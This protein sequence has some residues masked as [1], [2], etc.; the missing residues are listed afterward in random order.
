MPRLIVLGI[1]SALFFSS[2]FILNRSMSLE[3][4]HWAWSASLRFGY[5]LVFLAL[6]LLVTQGKKALA[7]VWSVFRAYWKFWVVAGSIGF[8][9]FYAL[10]TLSAQYAAGWIVATTWQTTILAT[11]L[12]LVFFGRKVPTKGLVFTG[13]IFVGIVLVNLEHAVSTSLR[14]LFWG[15]MPVL[16]AAVAYPL[17]N[18]LVWEVRVGENRHLPHIQHPIMANGFARVLLMTLGSMPF[19]VGLLVLSAPPA[20]SAGQWLNTALVA[21]FSGVFATTLFLY[22]RNL[23]QKPY[24]IAA[25]DATQSMEVVFSLLGEVIFLQGLLPG[26]LGLAGV[27]LTVLGLSAY[28]AM[29]R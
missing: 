1:L 25:V 15:V 27:A 6:I 19:W 14:G 26:A 29:Q 11:P 9:V 21:L 3:G 2:T 10:I 16:V 28:M 20:P 8:G 18:Q 17:G 24:E 22:A 23:C 7:E 13:V 12:V 5:M 4:G